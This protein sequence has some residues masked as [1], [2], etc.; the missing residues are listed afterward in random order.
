MKFNNHFL[1]NLKKQKLVFIS[2]LIIIILFSICINSHF[3]EGNENMESDQSQQIELLKTKIYE[4]KEKLLTDSEKGNDE[5]IS[6]EDF[7]DGDEGNRKKGIYNQ[8]INYRTQFFDLLQSDEKIKKQI[9]ETK[10]MTAIEINNL[11]LSLTEKV[12]ECNFTN[13]FSK[14][15]GINPS[16]NLNSKASKVTS[17]IKNPFS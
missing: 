17:G 15:I 8:I 16:L 10:D 11:L 4:E 7:L 12:S 13:K 3:K 6:I 9:S 1:Y 2:L 5:K 14:K